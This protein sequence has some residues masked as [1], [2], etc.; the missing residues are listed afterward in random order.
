LVNE[1]EIQAVAAAAIPIGTPSDCTASRRR[2]ART[3]QVG[4]HSLFNI[5]KIILPDIEP[6]TFAIPGNPL[7]TTIVTHGK[8]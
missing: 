1:V 5:R 2:S 4:A 8:A 6:N 3:S 7:L